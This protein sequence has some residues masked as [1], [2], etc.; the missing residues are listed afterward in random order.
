MRGREKIEREREREIKTVCVVLYC[1][2]CS[3][4]R[5]VT[6]GRESIARNEMGTNEAGGGHGR[7][8]THVYRRTHGDVLNII[9]AAGTE[10]DGGGGEDGD[11]VLDRQHEGN[12]EISPPRDNLA[13]SVPRT[14]LAKQLTTCLRVEN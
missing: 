14:G 1:S 3:V 12:R 5:S 13:Q 7:R 11:V 2:R 8:W 4:A 9:H 6:L 10:S